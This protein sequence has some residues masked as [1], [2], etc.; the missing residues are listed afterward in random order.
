[1]HGLSE[2]SFILITKGSMGE[3]RTEGRECC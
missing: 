2:F 3:G 1:V